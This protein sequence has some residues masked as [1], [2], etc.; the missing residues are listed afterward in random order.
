MVRSSI[1]SRCAEWIPR[2]APRLLVL[3]V[4]APLLAGCPIPVPVCEHKQLEVLQVPVVDLRSWHI[5]ELR[6]DAGIVL[7]R[8]ELRGTRAIGRISL[9]LVAFEDGEPRAER[10]VWLQP[11]GAFVWALPAG[12]YVV[13][14]A[15]LNYDYQGTSYQQSRNFDPG[16]SFRVK[17]GPAM[18]YLGTLRLNVDDNRIVRD[19]FHEAY[20][21]RSAAVTDEFAADRSI[22][23]AAGTLPEG[24]VVHQMMAYDPA[25]EAPVVP[26]TMVCH[27]WNMCWG[28]F[29]GEASACFNE[30]R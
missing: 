18:T 30:D 5:A 22:V 23:S 27:K 6:A 1:V 3:A 26:R 17:A 16:I 9:K 4:S 11:D 21:V 13:A 7:G 25:R 12:K 29:A 20:V 14:S 19:I 2:P 24:A 10:T 8:I 15:E 28:I